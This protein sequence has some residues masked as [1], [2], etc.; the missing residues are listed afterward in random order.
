M[1]KYLLTEFKKIKMATD[2]LALYGNN[3]TVDV[4]I[5]SEGSDDF[6]DTI[7]DLIGQDREVNNDQPELYY[8]Q[9]EYKDFKQVLKAIKEFL[10]NYENEEVRV[11]FIIRQNGI[12]E[13]Y[14]CDAD[15]LLRIRENT[16]KTNFR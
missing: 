15:T 3:V 5:T 14:G 9:G 10:S 8:V 6:T 4:S 2:V 16:I 13:E 1:L 7:N 12:I 11:E